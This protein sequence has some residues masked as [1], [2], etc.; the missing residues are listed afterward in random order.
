[1]SCGV[2]GCGAGKAA[3]KKDTK[4]ALAKTEKKGKK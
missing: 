4:K 3:P 2:K 1:M